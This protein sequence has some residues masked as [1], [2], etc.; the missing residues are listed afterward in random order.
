M[1]KKSCAWL[2][3]KIRQRIPVLLV[4]TGAQTGNALLG[5]L[6]ALG[7]RNVIDC[8]VTGDWPGFYTA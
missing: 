2:L 1:N 6:F 4:L 8:A 7:S 3:G 5:V